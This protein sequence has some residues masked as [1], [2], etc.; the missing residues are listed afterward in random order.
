MAKSKSKELFLQ[1]NKRTNHYLITY[2]MNIYF[3]FVF[4]CLFLILFTAG[5]FF[6]FVN[7]EAQRVLKSQILDEISQQSVNSMNNIERFIY[8]RISD[9]SSLSN[10]VILKNKQSKALEIANYLQKLHQLNEIYY[11][12]SYFDANR[13]RIA[14]SKNLEINKKHTL[15]NY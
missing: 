5:T 3:K 10:S 4:L 6:Y 12:F 14:D 7:I 1:K 8:E 13:I 15:K 11:S 9:I 2:P